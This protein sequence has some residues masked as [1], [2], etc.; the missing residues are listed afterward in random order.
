[1]TPDLPDHLLIL[2]PGFRRKPVGGIRVAFEYANWIQRNA[3]VQVRIGLN[4]SLLRGDDAPGLVRR[5]AAQARNLLVRAA[6]RDVPWFSLDP[7]VQVTQRASTLRRWAA[8]DTAIVGTE[9]RTWAAVRDLAAVRSDSR[10]AL[11]LQHHETWIA[12]DG[13]IREF[14]ADPALRKVAIAPWIVDEVRASGDDAVLVPNAIDLGDFP[15]GPPLAERPRKVVAMTSPVPRKRT[16]L[17][18]E[19]FRDLAR[20]GCDLETF[21][22]HPAPPELLPLARHT[23]SPSRE[24]LSEMLRSARVYLCASDAEGWHLPPA[25][26]LASGSAVVST[27]IPG[28][29]AYAD[30]AAAFAPVGDAPALTAGVLGLLDHPERAQR[31][32]DVGRARICGRT[33]GDA[34]RQFLEAV[35]S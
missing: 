35:V 21:G 3:P 13:Y 19:V 9:V 4:T 29:R 26:A 20:H 23:V 15:S 14:L 10:A 6:Y 31:L 12:S 1:M 25:E 30:G 17:V 32:V 33:P 2:L 16:D 22:V 5:S 28:V 27:D 7:A 24:H 11:F 34:A 18:T 8:D